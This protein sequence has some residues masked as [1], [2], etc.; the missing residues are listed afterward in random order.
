MANH[1]AA[2]FIGQHHLLDAIFFRDVLRAHAKRLWFFQNA[3][4]NTFK[5]LW[6]YVAGCLFPWWP[7]PTPKS[8]STSGKVSSMG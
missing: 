3:I 2:L 8:P 6:I 7:I 1:G 4:V 5:H